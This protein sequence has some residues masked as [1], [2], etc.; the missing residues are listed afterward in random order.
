MADPDDKYGPASLGN[1]RGHLQII[2]NLSFDGLSPLKRNVSDL[3]V[4]FIEDG[5]WP[6]LK[7]HNSPIIAL[8]R[9]IDELEK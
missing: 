9:L 3:S 7:G 4:E 5:F 2:A 1:Q 6:E 8:N